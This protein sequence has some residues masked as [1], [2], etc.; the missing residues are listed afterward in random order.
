MGLDNRVGHLFWALCLFGF[1]AILSSTLSKNPVLNPFAHAL[2]TPD[3]L[4]GFV[5]SASTIPG[6]LVSLPTASLSDI[7]GRRKILLISGLIF[8]SAPFLYLLVTTWWQLALVRF[9]H[10][11]A[12]AIFVPVT[13]AYVAELYPMKKGERISLFSSATTVGRNLAP[14]L[15]GYILLV[16][17]YGF[18][19]L[20]FAVGFS[21]LIAF[22]TALLFLKDNP[23]GGKEAGA[24]PVGISSE[25]VRGWGNVARNRRI[26]VV[27]LVEA[28]QYYVYGATE[29]FLVGYLSEVVRL[30][31]FSLGIIS[32]VQLAT[33]PLIK[34]LMGR[35]SDKIGRRVPIALGSLV[36][37]IALIAIPFTTS[38]AILLL[39]SISYGF[40]FSLVT[41][42][43]PALVGDLTQ[44]ELLGTS[45]G[46]LGMIMDVG[47]ALGPIITGFALATS[48]GYVGAFASLMIV[49]LAACSVFLLAKAG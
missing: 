12:T 45:M 31:P 32:W 3:S 38:F 49:L 4:M 43:T 1:M 35:L 25:T 44:R 30:D 21:G 13:N 29:F 28:A 7:F 16:T 10:G 41:S 18:H 11:F 14:L 46:F 39:I 34:P 20:Y 22:I 26:A 8:A 5:A 27:S 37:A 2:D 17:N 15:G 47:Q 9:Y 23:K 24:I 36:S 33:I 19:E 6:I 42:S 48:L 40:G